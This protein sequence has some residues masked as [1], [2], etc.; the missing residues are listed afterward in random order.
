MAAKKT[1]SLSNAYIDSAAYE[2]TL[3]RIGDAPAIGKTYKFHDRTITER[4]AGEA[5]VFARENMTFFALSWDTTD[6]EGYSTQVA[7][8]LSSLLQGFGITLDDCREALEQG[9]LAE[10][11]TYDGEEG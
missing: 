7:I 1:F 8:T 10:T 3:P 6:Y 9:T 2:K 5:I 4:E 11:V